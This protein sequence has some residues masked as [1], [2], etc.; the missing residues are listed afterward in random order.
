MRI[1]GGEVQHLQTSPSPWRTYT[2]PVPSLT[3]SQR[4]PRV[5]CVVNQDTNL[6][7]G[8]E[9]YTMGLD[10]VLARE[11]AVSLSNRAGVRYCRMLTGS[12]EWAEKADHVAPTTVGGS[13]KHGGPDLGPTRTREEWAFFGSKTQ[14]INAS[15]SGMRFLR[16]WL[17][18]SRE[19]WRN[20]FVDGKGRYRLVTWPLGK[21]PPR[22]ARNVNAQLR[23]RGT[24]RSLIAQAAHR[25]WI[26]T[27]TP[28]RCA[29]S[30][31]A[32]PMTGPAVRPVCISVTSWIRVMTARRRWTICERCAACA[33]RERTMPRKNR[34]PYLVDEPD[35]AGN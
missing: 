18:P 19:S 5:S 13:K 1:I 11:S 2:R 35:M 33:I 25:S 26:G 21:S 10:R 17:A 8:R 34:L 30:Q 14:T 27:A 31:R 12:D 22:F 23:A 6:L 24:V 4:A 28:A 16:R 7:W 3:G 29:E 9:A 20:A 15:R 32:I